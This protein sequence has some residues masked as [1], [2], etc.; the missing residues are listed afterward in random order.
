MRQRS[1]FVIP[2]ARRPSPHGSARPTARANFHRI[3]SAEV[4]RC[5]SA[6]LLRF[7]IHN[8]SLW[9]SLI[10]GMQ[11]QTAWNVDPGSA[12]KIDPLDGCVVTPL[13]SPAERIEVAQP[14]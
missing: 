14:G 2:A 12:S 8:L 10:R 5:P 3:A 4:D 6:A 11:C 7:R 13:V 9:I 1:A